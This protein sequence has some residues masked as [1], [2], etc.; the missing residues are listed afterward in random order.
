MTD[1]ALDPTAILAELGTTTLPRSVRCYT[2]VGSTMDLARESLATLPDEHLPLLITAELQTSG[3]G[4]LGRSWEAPSGTAL[5]ASLA[6]RP[7]WLAPERGAALAW[8][9]AVALCAAVEEV[10]GIR[11]GL[12]WPNDL[13]VPLRATDTGAPS[14]APAWAK[15]AGLLLEVSLNAQG[16]D[17]AIIGFGVNVSA[18]PPPTATL[19]PATSLV[20]AAGAPVSRL[21]LL[22]ALLRQLDHWHARLIAGDEAA[23]FAAWRA[24]LLTLGQQVSIET[25]N[26][27]VVGSAEDV[28]RAGGLLV[29]DATG[30]LHLITTGDVGLI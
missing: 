8:M 22:R 4:R 28:D 11:P 29:R 16:F 23:L 5:L 30:T 25:A 14:P 19:Y 1:E 27:T 6:L 26:G 2:T 24:R 17:W 7:T 15:A 10:T 18:A 3:R 20:E 13:L 9:I 12:K 21:A